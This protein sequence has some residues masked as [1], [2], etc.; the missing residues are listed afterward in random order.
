MYVEMASDHE[1][2]AFLAGMTP[3]RA[4][5]D[6]DP[7]SAVERKRMRFLREKAHLE[8]LVIAGRLQAWQLD[9]ALDLAA[10]S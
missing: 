10:V 4:A 3:A 7:L 6:L 9:V 5:R 8:A 1:F 2:S